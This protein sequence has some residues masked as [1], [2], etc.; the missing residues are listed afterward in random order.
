MKESK[1][2]SQQKYIKE[3]KNKERKQSL[4]FRVKK[5]RMI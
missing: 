1:I 4:G 3:T 2:G 5:G